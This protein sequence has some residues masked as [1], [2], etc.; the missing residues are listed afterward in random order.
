MQD[1]WER[2]FNVGV[3]DGDPDNDGITNIQE[4]R[5][6]SSPHIADRMS[7]VGSNSPLS[8]DPDAAALRMA[9]S[10]GRQ[11]WEWSGT[12]GA[13]ALAF[14]FAS[15]PGWTGAN[16]GAGAGIP[17]GFATVAGG[18]NLGQT[19]AAGRHRFSFNEFTGAYL[20]EAL[21]AAEEWRQ[22][23]GLD[24]DGDWADD[25]DGDGFSDAAEYALG[26]D[27]RDATDASGLKLFTV[28]DLGDGTRGM[29]I[30]WLQRTDDAA[31]QVLPFVSDTVGDP[32]GWF[33][34]NLRWH[35][36]RAACLQDSR[37]GRSFSRLLPAQG[38]CGFRCRACREEPGGG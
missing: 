13:G 7:L 10:D 17:A 37:G 18:D 3:P 35:P 24:E 36:T 29:A 34:P 5:R 38:F 25:S 1:E 16:Y 20:V 11:R 33:R 27:P 32:E 30:R 6:G 28:V 21:S 26:G 22:A 2:H 14:K 8:W 19:L 15:G 4:F 31:L 9:W 12:F 23:F